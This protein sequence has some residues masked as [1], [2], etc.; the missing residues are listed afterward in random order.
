MCDHKT[1]KEYLM[2]RNV[3]FLTSARALVFAVGIAITGTVG[4]ASS[5]QAASDETLYT[6][7]WSPKGGVVD[8]WRYGDVVQVCDRVADGYGVHLRVVDSSQVLYKY[9][10]SVGGNGR[11]KSAKAAMGNPYNLREGNQ[12]EFRICLEKDNRLYDCNTAYW[13][14]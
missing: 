12:F 1:I 7:D 13:W 10:L 6:N 9:S 8:F 14:N 3:R 11:C 2:R 4:L 5:A